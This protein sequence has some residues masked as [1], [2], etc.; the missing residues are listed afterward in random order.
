[1]LASLGLPPDEAEAMVRTA[2]GRE[3]GGGTN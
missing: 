1:V 2:V 3:R